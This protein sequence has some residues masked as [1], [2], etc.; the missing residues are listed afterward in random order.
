MQ[1]NPGRVRSRSTTPAPR[2][3]A[4]SNVATNPPSLRRETTATSTEQVPQ[5]PSPATHRAQSPQPPPE[6]AGG[7]AFPARRSV[8]CSTISP[9]RFRAITALPPSHPL[10]LLSLGA[11]L[12]GFLEMGDTGKIA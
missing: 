2:R 6:N 7:W 9:S 12:G 11:I 10:P 8:P 3:T 5:P 1:T 4:S